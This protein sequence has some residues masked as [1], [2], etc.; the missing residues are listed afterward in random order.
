[1]SFDAFAQWLNSEEGQDDVAD[2]HWMSQHRILALDQPGLI[3]YDFVGRLE[4]L[5]DDY[6]RLVE[7]TKLDLPPLTH[8]LKTQAPDD[9]RKLY[10]EQSV[11][12]IAK[13]YQRD[14]ELF[15]YDFDDTLPNIEGRMSRVIND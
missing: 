6:E 8:K 12:Q 13:R 3:T 11:E 5:S 2:R 14:I 1:M 7:I 10:N 15:G 9:F 4:N